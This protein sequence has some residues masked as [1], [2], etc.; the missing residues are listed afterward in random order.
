MSYLVLA[1]KWR[2]QIFE[3][4][5]GQQPIV[6]TLKNALARNRVAHAMIFSGVRGVGKTT[7]ARIMAKALNCETDGERPCNQCESCQEI[8]KGVSLDLNEIDGASNR[9]IQEIRELK[10]NIRFLPAKS[11]FKIIIIDE[12][13]MLTTEAFNALLKTLEEP[14]EHVYFMFATTELHKVPITIL[15]RCQRY[16]LKRVGFDE[17]VDFLKKIAQAEDVS[18]PRASLEKIA[19]ESEGSIRDGLSLLDQIFSF[20]GNEVKDE[21]VIEV[22]G[23]VDRQVYE[24]LTGRLLG[25]SLSGSLDLLDRCYSSGIDLKRFAG[26]LLLFVRSML[27]SKVS[28]H[29]EQILDLSDNDLERLQAASAAYS[30]ETLSQLF[31]VLLKGVEELH[32]SSHPRM[33]LEM[34]FIKVVESSQVVAVSALLEKVDSLLQNPGINAGGEEMTRPSPVM[35]ESL[36][37]GPVAKKDDGQSKDD[38]QKISEEKARPS[39]RETPVEVRLESREDMP[40]VDF[41]SPKEER[42]AGSGNKDVRKHWDEF[43]EYVLD[44]KRWMAHVLRLSAGARQE[45]GNLVLKFE[46]VSE[47][48]VLQQPE[49]VKVLTEFAQDFFQRELKIKF[50]L[51][52][53]DSGSALNGEQK[54]PQEERRALA[55]DPLVQMT[56]EIF[57]G[58]VVNIRTGP[59]S[60]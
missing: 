32:Y 56:T 36:M 12:V 14:P 19:R 52:G 41:S 31:Q 21:D 2:P 25:G 35:P 1:R 54:G 58:Q 3:D 38:E 16:E 22:L 15:S 11:Q 27:I 29:P 42:A 24:D 20:C 47:C 46:A 6:R 48:K 51:P 34:T 49:N 30:V 26:D 13:H 33:V 50:S 55:N 7:L 10:E 9:G 5:V 60:R 18:I 28:S 43:V 8:T 59:R 53:A 17:L 45:D 44:R 4:V 37:A 57:G 40:P 39:A 23:L